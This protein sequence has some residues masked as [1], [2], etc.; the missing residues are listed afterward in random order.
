MSITL[1]TKVFTFAGI[2]AQGISTYLNGGDT[3]AAS[4]SL[5]AKIDGVGGTG[6]TKVR[7][8]LKLPVVSEDPSCACPGGLNH[9]SFVDIVVT[10]APQ[11][12]TV[13]RTAI[14][15]SIS[16]LVASPEFQASITSLILPSS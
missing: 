3:P 7:W 15:T 14:Q 5:T 10:L 12:S 11:A 16:D 6:N 9:T 2:L 4:N 13:E 8:K 1:A